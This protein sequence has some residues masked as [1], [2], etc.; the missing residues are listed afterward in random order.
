MGTTATPTHKQLP[1]RVVEIERMEWRRWNKKK[2][3]RAKNTEF[4]K[5]K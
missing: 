5:K 4:V 2:K 3:K 1:N